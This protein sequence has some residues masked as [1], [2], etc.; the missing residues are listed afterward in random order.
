MILTK[1][2]LIFIITVFV[3]FFKW[4]CLIFLNSN[5]D[6]ITNIV[7]NI[8]DHQYFPLIYNLSNLDFY[9]SYDNDLTIKNSLPFPIYSIIFHSV[10]YKIFN[11]YGFIIIE[12]F[13]IFIFFY[14]LSSFLIKLGLDQPISILITLL[15][16]MNPLYIDI[17]SLKFNYINAFKE[18]YNLRIPRPSVSSL[19]LFL[20]LNVI[21]IKTKE[22]QYS[23]SHLF[24]IGAV[25]A[26]LFSSF[27][28]YLALCGFTFLII[29]LFTQLKPL[30]SIS[31]IFGD[32][33]KILGSF[34]VFSIPTIFLLFK[35]E[36]DYLIRVGLI[37]LDYDQK[38]I[39]VK[40]YSERILSLPFIIIFSLITFF[41]FFLKSKNFYNNNGL[42]L[43]YILFLSSFISPIIF[44]IFSPSIS[45]IYHFSNMLVG[46][47]LFVLFI[48]FCM[49]VNLFFQSF[50][51]NSTS[52]FFILFLLLSFF[53]Y[54]T[55]D[56]LKKRSNSD[57][58][59]FSFSLMSNIKEKKINK[60]TEILVFDSKNQVNL[61]LHDYTN[62]SFALGIYSPINDNE[63]ENKIIESFIYLGLEEND[64]L[65][66]LK[67]RKVKGRGYINPNV[68][69]TFYMKYQ[70]NRLKTYENSNDF[71]ED[72]LSYISKVPILSNQQLIIPKFELDRLIMKFNNYK[73]KHE[74]SPKIIILN[75]QTDSFYEEVILS[76]EHFCKI[77]INK[78]YT[79]YF[80]KDIISKCG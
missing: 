41:L 2:K 62:L 21:L 53:S 72:E 28:Y 32:L 44:I 55:Y 51:N 75:K 67:N 58:K 18:I 80:M 57:E 73:V 38:L 68:G 40:H 60:D 11:I 43:L 13:L 22:K 5:I 52:L 10:F 76:N 46:I 70:A 27:Y 49:I 59:Q 37:D 25:F 16:F 15:I 79:I 36:P 78:I 64:F 23:F 6:L 66:F 9:P 1:N 63:L 45:E 77:D 19:Y 12:F 30:C 42:N 14:L 34:I 29:Y 56:N 47:S 48:Y 7:F 71:F 65:N 8:D 3:F 33:L 69:K 35:A 74:I 24:L 39:L 61:I 31:K 4:L 26:F 20:F 50:F 17:L 54:M